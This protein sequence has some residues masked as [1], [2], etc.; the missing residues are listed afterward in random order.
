MAHVVTL[1]V[2]VLGTLAWHVAGQSGPSEVSP[3]LPGDANEQIESA[4]ASMAAPAPTTEP[5]PRP[6]GRFAPGVERWRLASRDAAQTAQQATGVNLD[7]NIMLALVAVESEGAPT[8]RSPRGAV[9]LAQV[10][11]ATFK[12]LRARYGD[13][14]PGGSL[15]EPRVNLLAGALYLAECARFLGSDIAIPGE[16]ALVL[17][18]Y[19]LGPRAAAEWRDSGAWTDETT[20]GV[21]VQHQLPQETVE[22]ASRIL[23]AV[24]AAGG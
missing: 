6:A 23:A 22:H 12:D 18:A 13:L 15:E 14:L 1:G 11:P 9:G 2:V 19:N 4:T 3:L 20:A 17:H 7:E 21:Q 8:A 16:L 5:T 24:Y 10:E